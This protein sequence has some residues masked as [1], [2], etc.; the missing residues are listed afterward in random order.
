MRYKLYVQGPDNNSTYAECWGS[1]ATS[2]GRLVREASR[3]ADLIE[4]ADGLGHSNWSVRDGHRREWMSPEEFWARKA[5]AKA[6]A[7]ER[8]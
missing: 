3:L 6:T 4:A 2:P 5:V 1:T 7:A 8:E